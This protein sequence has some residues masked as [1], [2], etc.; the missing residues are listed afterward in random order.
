MTFTDRS[1]SQSLAVA[2]TQLV[3]E[4]D[5]GSDAGHALSS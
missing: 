3:T 4:N 1:M 2:G 5:T